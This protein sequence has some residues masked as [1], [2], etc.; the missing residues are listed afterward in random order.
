MALEGVLQ[1]STRSIWLLELAVDAGT[2]TAEKTMGTGT[3][4]RTALPRY[5]TSPHTHTHTPHLM[6]DSMIL[7]LGLLWNSSSL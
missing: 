2:E 7:V 5:T 1:Y 4:A 3:P 6:S